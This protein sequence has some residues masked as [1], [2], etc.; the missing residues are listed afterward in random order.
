[1]RRL[2]G[3]ATHVSACP[4]LI[5]LGGSRSLPKLLER[6]GGARRPYAP[7]LTFD[8]PREAL[9]CVHRAF[10]LCDS[11]TAPPCGRR[12]AGRRGRRPR[13]RDRPPLVASARLARPRAARRA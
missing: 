1:P 6:A 7:A 3:G 9:T 4:C 13:R 12:R 10:S 11:G 2:V 8:P 5:C